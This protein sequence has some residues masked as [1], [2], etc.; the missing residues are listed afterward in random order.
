MTMTLTGSGTGTVGVPNVGTA[1]NASGTSVDFTGIPAGIKRITVMFNNLSTNGSSN[2][3]V[4]IGSGSFTTTGYI[5]GAGMAG[6]LSPTTGT[7]GF[8]LAVG[9][10][11]GESWQGCITIVN[12]TGNQWV[13]SGA[14]S[15][16]ASAY[17]CC[18][19]GGV[20]LGGVLDRVRVTTA[21]GTDA[22][23]AGSINILY[24]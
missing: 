4:Q 6:G 5:S 22:F 8:L 14:V 12:L 7:A 1:Q 3:Q 23:D 21:N 11:A 10:A 18:S 16:A 19:S 17:C 24:E 13:Q 15:R 2:Y 9:T 20:T